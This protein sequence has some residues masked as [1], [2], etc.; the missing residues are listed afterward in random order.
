LFLS[1]CR[2]DSE[3]TERIVVILDYL[4]GPI[5][6]G[7]YAA[8]AR[9]DYTSAGLEVEILTPTST[10]ETLRLM[11]GDVA[12]VGLGPLLDFY[13]LR[14]EQRPLR[15]L[16]GLV[17]APLNGII[18]PEES[19]IR[20]PRDLEGRTI[21]TTGILGDEIMV[22]SLVERD[23]GE[24]EKVELLNVGFNTIQALASR[25]VDAAFGFWNA[26]G[27]QYAS[28]HPA[29]ILRSADYGIP[30]YP[31][32]VA[33]V[34]E[35]RWE[36]RKDALQRFADITLAS[37]ERLLEQPDEAL[38]LFAKSV[39]GY[40]EDSARPY[41]EA[42]LPVFKGDAPHYGELDPAVLEATREWLRASGFPAP[43]SPVDT[44][45]VP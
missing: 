27:I 5:H 43:E 15:L 39:D 44:L 33:F 34:R 18:V 40:T 9:G 11:A 31:E 42:L 41:F 10:S 2:R 32:I 23:G 20:R 45:P 26:E 22:R 12:D 19:S 25:K 1:G 29:R 36:E 13:Q 7:F 30:N 4:P 21:A 6:A 16:F 38:A 3:Q 17:Q 24:P 14:N 8:Q 37:Y 28:Q 35:D